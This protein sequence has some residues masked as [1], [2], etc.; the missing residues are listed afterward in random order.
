MVLLFRLIIFQIFGYPNESNMAVKY[1][2]D[3]IKAQNSQLSVVYQ[4]KTSIHWNDIVKLHMLS[5]SI[6]VIIHQYWSQLYF[7]KIRDK[8]LKFLSCSTLSHMEKWR[9]P[10]K[11]R[12]QKIQWLILLA[13]STPSGYDD[14][15]STKSPSVTTPIH[16]VTITTI[17]A[18]G[19]RDSILAMPY[20]GSQ[21]STSECVHTCVCAC[22]R[23]LVRLEATINNHMGFCFQYNEHENRATSMCNVIEY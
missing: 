15:L 9:R 12:D 19:C 23:V 14:M 11:N 7:C 8:F 10:V 5:C 21:N 1:K 20:S 13:R 6:N 18:I 16:D 2:M 17:T 4:Y 22:V 3:P